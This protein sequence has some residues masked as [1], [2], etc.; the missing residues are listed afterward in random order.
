MTDF[1]QELGSLDF[2]NIIGGPLTAVVEAQAHAAET[3][4]E[5][6]NEVGLTFEDGRITPIKTVFSYQKESTDEQ[7]VTRSRTHNIEV[8]VLAIVPIPYMV[9]N[10]VWLNF[11]VNLNSVENRSHNSF[12]GGSIAGRGRF[13]GFSFSGSVAA[14]RQKRDT[15]TVSKT[16]AMGV[17]IHAVQD[18]MP[19]GMER[20]LNILEQVAKAEVK[21]YNAV[22]QIS[23]TSPSGT[24]FAPGI[25]YG[26][27]GHIMSWD[28]D[29]GDGYGSTE[30][31]DFV[32]DVTESSAWLQWQDVPTLG[33]GTGETNSI[34][35]MQGWLRAVGSKD[36]DES[37]HTISQRSDSKYI[38][39]ENGN[40]PEVDGMI[41][42]KTMQSIVRF[43]ETHY[44]GTAFNFGTP[45]KVKAA[46]DAIKAHFCGG[47]YDESGTGAITSS[48]AWTTSAHTP[49]SDTT[50]GDK[51][52]YFVSQEMTATGAADGFWEIMAQ[53]RLD[54]IETLGRRPPTIRLTIPSGGSAS[55]FSMVIADPGNCLIGVKSDGTVSSGA[56]EGA[57]LVDDQ[58]ASIVLKVD[59]DV[60][61]NGKMESIAWDDPTTNPTPE[62]GSVTHASIPLFASSGIG[63]GATANITIS[64]DCVSSISIDNAG[65]GY[66]VGDVLT[67][68][69][70]L[71]GTNGNGFSVTVTEV[72]Q[73]ET[74][75]EAVY[76]ATATGGTGT[77][78]EVRVT[79]E[80]GGTARFEIVDGGRDYTVGDAVTL[81][82][83]GEI[84][85]PVIEVT[86]VG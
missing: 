11:N 68:D 35:T 78:L 49:F 39:S 79:V 42:R 22:K 44:S 43:A 60:G 65:L 63:V 6:I 80:S 85:N 52:G 23:E 73:T 67:V 8:P 71:L 47:D 69:N 72:E 13:G 82:A 21:P 86:Q 45:A 55:S 41:G 29:G 2:E 84:G 15:G 32:P 64:G 53:L 27:D 74:S 61:A 40:L 9:F 10:D 1:G 18:E 5:F 37:P 48:T 26:G 24:P 66:E 76:L 28:F 17:K 58:N 19:E 30:T 51:I 33:T 54:Y 20:V 57:T 62:M 59:F 70:F 7:G 75:I 38:Q 4:I 81:S 14:S 31:I 77:G 34:K 16:Y 25:E 56:I 12:T 3:S 46:V 50:N 36:S 83:P